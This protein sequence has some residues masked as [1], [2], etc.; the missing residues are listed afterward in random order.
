MHVNDCI[1]AFTKDA[2]ANMDVTFVPLLNQ[3]PDLKPL[4]L[5]IVK[6]TQCLT[7]KARGLYVEPSSH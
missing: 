1:S 7:P 5:R 6:I 4:E 2:K 3:H